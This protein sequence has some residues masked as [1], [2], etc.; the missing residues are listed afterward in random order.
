MDRDL[1]FTMGLAISLVNCYMTI[2][3]G[4]YDCDRIFDERGDE[5]SVPA[6][7]NMTLFF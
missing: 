7:G 4:L 6:Y 3:Y 1:C 2:R 5:G